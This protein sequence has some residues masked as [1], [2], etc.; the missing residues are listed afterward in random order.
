MNARASYSWTKRVAIAI[1]WLLM[2]G[3]IATW[4]HEYDTCKQSST[5]TSP[6]A[7]CLATSL[8]SAYFTLAIDGPG[9]VL[10]GGYGAVVRAA[11]S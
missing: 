3:L 9:M 1:V 2:I 10:K 8:F 11:F 5:S 4:I 7:F 6:Q